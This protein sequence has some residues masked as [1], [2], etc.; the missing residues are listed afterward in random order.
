MM[1]IERRNLVRHALASDRHTQAGK[2]VWIKAIRALVHEQQQM[3]RDTSATDVMRALSHARLE[4]VSE[5]VKDEDE[6]ARVVVTMLQL[7]W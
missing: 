2:A 5:H 4:L 6:A 3:H 1:N 7:D